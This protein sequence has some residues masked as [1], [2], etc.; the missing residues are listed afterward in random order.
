MSNL[1]TSRKGLKLGAGAG[2]TLKF[3][4]N[5]N[6]LNVTTMARPMADTSFAGMLIQTQNNRSPV[7]IGGSGGTNPIR[8]NTISPRPNPDTYT[9][10]RLSTKNMNDSGMP[11]G[12]GNNLAQVIQ[13]IATSNRKNVTKSLN[14]SQN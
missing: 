9:S 2:A 5:N 13:S 14:K 6:H 8:M 11:T 7:N 4:R 10:N 12:T 1:S 3:R